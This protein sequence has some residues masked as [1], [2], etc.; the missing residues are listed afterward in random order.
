MAGSERHPEERSTVTL[1]SH[2]PGTGTGGGPLTDPDVRRI[3][4]STA[5]AIAERSGVDLLERIVEPDAM[6]LTIAGPTLVALGFAAELRRV[7]ESWHRAKYG[8]PLWSE[9]S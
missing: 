7:T 3:V 1:R 2:G 6:R 4:V 8:A 5:E 9:P